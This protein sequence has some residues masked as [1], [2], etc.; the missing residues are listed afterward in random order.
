VLSEQRGA[1]EAVNAMDA[2]QR[3]NHYRELLLARTRKGRVQGMGLADLARHA[4]GAMEAVT[5]DGVLV[6]RVRI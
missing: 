2:Q 1:V 3:R 5:R 4:H 6:V